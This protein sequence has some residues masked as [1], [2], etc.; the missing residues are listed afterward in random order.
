MPQWPDNVAE[1]IHLQQLCVNVLPLSRCKDNKTYHDLF[2]AAIPWLN[3]AFHVAGL[4]RRLFERRDINRLHDYFKR[5]FQIVSSTRRKTAV[6]KTYEKVAAG[7]ADL[8]EHLKP[9]GVSNGVRDMGEQLAK[10]V[11]VYID[12]QSGGSSF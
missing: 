11:R 12:R 2:E 8:P 7:Y 1:A 9:P 6:G 4:S 5:L 10:K 3:N